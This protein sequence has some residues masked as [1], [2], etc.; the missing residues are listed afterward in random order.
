MVGERHRQREERGQAEQHR[1]DRA[2]RGADATAGRAAHRPRSRPSAC[3]ARRP[4]R[5]GRTRRRP[6]SARARS[7]RRR[8]RGGRA[9]P[10]RSAATATGAR[11]PRGRPR[12]GR[13]ASRRADRSGGS[14]RPAAASSSTPRPRTS[15]RRRRSPSRA[16][17]RDEHAA[18]GVADWRRWSAAAAGSRPRRASS[19]GGTVSRVIARDDGWLSAARQPLSAPM[20]P[21]IG[22]VANPAISEA[23]GRPGSAHC[24]PAEPSIISLRGSRSPSTPPKSSGHDLGEREGRDDQAELG[25]RAAEV[26]DGEGERDRRD[27]VAER[28][29]RRTADEEPEVPVAQGGAG[30]AFTR[31]R[32]YFAGE[33]FASRTGTISAVT[34]GRTG[35]TATSPAGATTGST[36]PSRTTSRRSSSGSAG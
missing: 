19:S 12:R 24:R 4:T 34:D 35:P 1:P 7:A 5:S 13:P 18:E 33:L 31:A 27:R 3:R 17:D 9:S 8:R 15:A 26:E 10:A 20:M 14:A 6:R 2:G 36:S 30:G 29:G 32:Y 21:S 11:A 28:A 23:R 25:G 16:D 22:I